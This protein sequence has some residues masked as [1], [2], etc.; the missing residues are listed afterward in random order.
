VT[1][2]GGSCSANIGQT[3]TSVPNACGAT[4]AGLTQCNGS[5]SAGTP[6]V[7]STCPPPALSITAVPNFVRVGSNVTL[8]WSSTHTQNCSVSGTDGFKSSGAQGTQTYGPIIGTVFYTFTCQYLYDAST[9]ISTF[10]RV[11]IIPS[12]KEN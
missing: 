7:S 11:R 2:F 4:I 1:V 3:C 5:C 12:V 8:N 10:S 9:Q 6:S